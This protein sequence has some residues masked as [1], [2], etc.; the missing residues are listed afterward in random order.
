LRD[1]GERELRDIGL[2]LGRDLAGFVL[3]DRFRDRLDDKA[4]RREPK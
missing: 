3:V 2:A 1:I 4:L